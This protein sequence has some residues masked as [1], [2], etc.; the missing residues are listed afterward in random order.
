MA[1]YLS[2][3]K[4]GEGYLTIEEFVFVCMSLCLV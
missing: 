2:L 1:D 3:G 4:F